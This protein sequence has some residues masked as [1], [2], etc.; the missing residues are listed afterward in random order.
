MTGSENRIMKSQKGSLSGM[1]FSNVREEERES[2]TQ[3][4]R[5]EREKKE[6]VR[7]IKI[8]K[9]QRKRGESKREERE[10]DGNGEKF[11]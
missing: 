1:N 4:E 3:R 10:R 11:Y 8:N 5:E 7:E 6:R 9:G 2:Y